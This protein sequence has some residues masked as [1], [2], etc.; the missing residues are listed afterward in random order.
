MTEIYL[1][2]V[3]TMAFIAELHIILYARKSLKAIIK[4]KG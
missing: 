3:V 4:R 1:M 2:A